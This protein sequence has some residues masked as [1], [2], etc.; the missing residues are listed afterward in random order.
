MTSRTVV[1]SVDPVDGPPPNLTELDA[2]LAQLRARFPGASIERYLQHVPQLDE[3]VH[4]APTAALVGR[5]HLHREVSIWH[6]AVLRAD[7]NSIEVRERSNIQDG[8]VV[9][10]GDLDPTFIAEEVV[11]GHRAVLHGC[12]VEGG[13]LI[14]IGAIVLDGARV[15]HGSV[16]GASALVTTGMVIPPHSLVLGAPARVVRTLNSQ[17]EDHHRA[18]AL[19]YVR[20]AGNYRGG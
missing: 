5:V 9:H 12:H 10:L 1:D 16:V 7:I 3:L 11:V 8:S 18:L 6:G 19:K 17:D 14:G 15:G 20:I 2:R 4:V 13:S